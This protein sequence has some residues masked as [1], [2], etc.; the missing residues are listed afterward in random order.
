MT[1]IVYID[2]DFPEKVYLAHTCT[3]VLVPSNSEI[4]FY[5]NSSFIYS[6]IDLLV[7]GPLRPDTVLGVRSI[8]VDVANCL[9][10]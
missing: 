10:L 3:C 1:Q 8:A 6:F 9:P 4:F 5:Y 7:E 2:K